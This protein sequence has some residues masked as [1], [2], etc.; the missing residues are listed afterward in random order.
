MRSFPR[1]AV[2]GS[3]SAPGAWMGV[4]PLEV[5]LHEKFSWDRDTGQCPRAWMSLRPLGGALFYEVSG[6]QRERLPS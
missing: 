5:R 3:A 1:T 6:N 2:L 4:R